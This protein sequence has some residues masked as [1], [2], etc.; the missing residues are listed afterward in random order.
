MA[1]MALAGPIR[2]SQSR[3]W[4]KAIHPNTK[5]PYEYNPH[6]PATTSTSFHYLNLRGTDT[7]RK[8]L[9]DDDES[10]RPPQVER[11]PMH[12]SSSQCVPEPH[13]LS[14]TTPHHTPLGH[15]AAAAAVHT[16][17]FFHT[18]L[19]PPSPIVQLLRLAAA[20][21]IVVHPI[22]VTA[23]LPERSETCNDALSSLLL[24]ALAYLTFIAGCHF[25]LFC[26][27]SVPSPDP[28]PPHGGAAVVAVV[29]A[30][31][32]HHVWRSPLRKNCTTIPSG[33][34]SRL[35]R[36]LAAGWQWWSPGRHTLG[37]IW[38]F[39][40][41]PCLHLTAATIRKAESRAKE[42]SIAS[43]FTGYS[44]PL[45]AATPIRMAV[46]HDLALEPPQ[47]RF[48]SRPGA[49]DVPLGQDACHCSPAW[50]SNRPAAMVLGTWKSPAHSLP[51]AVLCPFPPFSNPPCASQT[52]HFVTSQYLA[53]RAQYGHK[54][55]TSFL[56]ST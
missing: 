41:S 6:F 35:I 42:R 56:G 7:A 43:A 15:A 50:A 8:N 52:M 28:F 13:P 36:I 55:N 45:D 48:M 2:A 5:P 54:G 21:S 24:L 33:G 22:G 40:T 38:Y 19:G 53:H 37:C 49:K 25:L 1:P 27:V 46:R 39:D 20:S 31:L 10:G 11:T 34:P 26:P 44:M 4:A 16:N 17:T 18:D 30:Q 12:Q 14:H 3:L 32:S 29:V 23:Q 47:P 9:R 51:Q